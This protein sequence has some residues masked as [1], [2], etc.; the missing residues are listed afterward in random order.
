MTAPQGASYTGIK[1]LIEEWNKI[2]T[3]IAKDSRIG[4]DNRHRNLQVSLSLSVKTIANQKG[5]IQLWSLASLFPEGI[6]PEEQN[7]FLDKNSFSREDRFSLINKNILRNID[8]HLTLLP[9]VA[10]YAEDMLRENK[11]SFIRSHFFETA[12]P[13]FKE[14]VENANQ[15]KQGEPVWKLIRH[16]PSIRRFM[17]FFTDTNTQQQK[18]LKLNSGFWDY[19]DRR[20]F[21]GLEIVEKILK[22]Y[23]KNLSPT[24][25]GELHLKIGEML[26]F[27][28]KYQIAKNHLDQS[29]K[30]FNN[31]VSILGRGYVFYEMGSLEMMIGNIESAKSW[32]NKSIVAFEQEKSVLKKAN[33]QIQLAYIEMRLGNY[34]DARDLFNQISSIIEEGEQNIIRVNLFTH[35]GEL[36]MHLENHFQSR[37]YYNLAMS[38]SE[39][40]GYNLGRANIF[41]NMAELEIKEEN[42]SNANIYINEALNSYKEMSDKQGEYNAYLFYSKLLLRLEK[43]PQLAMEYIIKSKRGC[44]I[45]GV[46]EGVA[47]SGFY[48]AEAYYQMQQPEK[49]LE[50]YL[51]AYNLAKEL[52]IAPLYKLAKETAAIIGIREP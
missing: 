23:S 43:N 12:Y 44:Q 22:N 48:S 37:E 42:I 32:F 3:A 45:I 50:H 2:G 29:L 36:E 4:T 47:E 17:V 27:L 11:S 26:R 14:L 25:K 20:P 30:Y 40:M 18:I 6:A 39:Q 15:I 35:I 16:F 13:W 33:S 49:A 52:N 51:E 10:R 9:P 46:K 41:L 7:W 8:G 5:A 24:A 38:L 1:E 34:K 31:P 28:A 19:Y 21:L